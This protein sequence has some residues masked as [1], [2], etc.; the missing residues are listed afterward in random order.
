[1]R[2]VIFDLWDTL[3]DF[4]VEEA[5]AAERRIADR[6][7]ME[8]DRFRELWQAGMR[9]RYVGSVAEAFRALGIDDELVPELVSVRM[10]V[11]RRGLV[12]RQGAVETLRALR[13]GGKRLGLISV[14]SEEV[15]AL[16]DETGFAG[17]FDSTVFSCAVGLTKPDPR[18]YLLACDELGVEPME[19]LFVGDGANDELAGAERVGMRAVLIHRPGQE[20]T[21][22]EVKDWAGPRITSVPEI[23]DLV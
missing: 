20:P 15:P 5:R 13:S 21:W 3:A 11:A 1:M 4:D 16:W 6:V 12:P 14:C 19:C 8:H 7:G 10:E 2:A 18:I 17:L 9:E 23:L 22:A